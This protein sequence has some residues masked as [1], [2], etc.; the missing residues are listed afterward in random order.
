MTTLP[1]QRH[2]AGVYT[3]SGSSHQPTVNGVYN[4]VALTVNGHAYYTKGTGTDARVMYWQ[5]PASGGQWVIADQ[6]GK[7]FRASEAQQ[8]TPVF[9]PPHRSGWL[10]WN[11]K[12]VPEASIV[13]ASTTLPGNHSPK[14]RYKTGMRCK[15]EKSEFSDVHSKVPSMGPHVADFTDFFEFV[16]PWVGFST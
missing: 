11:K 7:S 12:W 9:G 10:S 2:L 6:V 5:P 14:M 3:V 15:T 8:A 1:P 16:V 4:K 13:V